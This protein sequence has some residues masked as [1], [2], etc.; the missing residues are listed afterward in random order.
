MYHICVTHGDRAAQGY[1]AGV[2]VGFQASFMMVLGGE[3]TDSNDDTCMII[4]TIYYYFTYKCISAINFNDPS[5]L[6]GMTP[7][8][9]S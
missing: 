3:D 7:K 1:L 4:T 8:Y 9:W 6:A 5:N 2:L